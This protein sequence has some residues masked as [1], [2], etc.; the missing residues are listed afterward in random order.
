[1][2]SMDLVSE[3]KNQIPVKHTFDKAKTPNGRTLHVN[4]SFNAADLKV[5]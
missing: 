3:K 5:S 1:M 4:V 2:F